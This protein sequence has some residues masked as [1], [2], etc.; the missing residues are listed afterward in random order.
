VNPDIRLHIAA[1]AVVLLVCAGILA[2]PAAAAA[3]SPTHDY[4]VVKAIEWTKVI[5]K[6]LTMDI[7]TPATGKPAYPVLVIYHGGGWLIN[8]NAIMDSMAVYMVRHA[9]IVVCNVNFRLLGDL[10]NTVTMNQIIEDALGAIAWIKEHIGAYQGDA[11]RLIVTGDSSGGHMAA[12]V[13]LAS[14][15]LDSDG[16]AG[17]ALGFCPTWL[18]PGKTAE[19]LAAS[20]ALDVQGAILSYGAFDIY[21]AC[22]AGM[23]TSGNIFWALAGKSPRK[24]FGTKYNYIQNA[25]MYK[26]VSPIFIIPPASERILP[27]QLCLVGSKDTTTPPA[28]VKSYVDSTV[29]AGQAIEYWVYDDKPHAFLDATPNSWLGTQFTRD[30]PPALDKMIDWMAV[31]HLTA[32]ESR[33]QRSESGLRLEQNH[34]NPFN[35]LTSISFYLD[36]AD[37][38]RLTVHDLQGRRV[39]TLTDGFQ[40][41]GLQHFCFD[42]TGLA[43]GFYFCRLESG[44]GRSQM[45]RMLLLK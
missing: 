12:M 39:C 7:Y 43:G 2:V 42:A 44:R 18:P 32:V 34:P 4:T 28:S 5:N 15:T 26:A 16:F 30:A 45:I 25:G 35:A 36:E 29:K 41:A 1:A 38:I 9:E 10:G 8:T 20:H 19:E 14:R 11:A 33:T 23:E 40:P 24:L 6:S 31:H 17:A 3:A 22:K 37:Q 13:L 27:P 21:A